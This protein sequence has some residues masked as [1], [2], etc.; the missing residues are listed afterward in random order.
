MRQLVKEYA[1]SITSSLLTSCLNFFGLTV[2][3]AVCMLLM[4][5]VHSETSFERWLP[6]SDK[7]Y[8]V[9]QTWSLPGVRPRESFSTSGALLDAIRADFPSVQVVRAMDRPGTVQLNGEAIE[10]QVRLVDSDFLRIFPFKLSGGSESRALARPDGL[11]ISDRLARRYFGT[12]NALGMQLRITIGDDQR[13]YQVTGVLAPTSERSD[14]R[15]DMFLRLSP[16]RQDPDTFRNW[17]ATMLQTFVRFDTPEDAAAFERQLPAL[18]QRRAIA[19]LGP[20]VGEQLKLRLVPLRSIHLIEEDDRT[21]VG[22]VGLIGLLTLL[23]ACINYVTLSTARAGLRAREIAIRKVVGATRNRLLVQFLAEAVATV[24]IAGVLALALVELSL[25]W[26]NALMATD[27]ELSYSGPDS[28]LSEFAL[29]LVLVGILAGAYPALFLSSFRPA[30][31]LASAREAGGGWRGA[32]AREL[33]V[34]LQF[35]I[36]VAFMIATAVVTLQI[37]FM[38]GTDLGFERSGLLLIPSSRNARL[39]EQQ[40]QSFM[41]RA[42]TIPGFIS[43]TSSDAAPGND[44]V[45]NAAGVRRPGMRGEPPSLNVVVTGPRFFPTYGARVAAGRVFSQDFGMDDFFATQNVPPE[46]ALN[47]VILNRSA[48]ATLNF[49]EPGDALGQRLQI[50]LPAGRRQVTVVGVID[51]LRFNSLRGPVAPTVYLFQSREIPTPVLAIRFSGQTLDGMEAQ[52][53]RLWRSLAPDVPFQTITAEESLAR[54]YTADV[55]RSRVFIAASCVAMLVS[56]LGLY[57]LAYFNAARR[58]K[59]IGIRKALGATRSDILRLMTGQMLRPVL[60][61]NLIAWPLAYLAMQRWLNGF[62]QR[63]DLNPLIFLGA[64]IVALAIAAGTI[65]ARALKIART[66]PAEALRHE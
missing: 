5:F 61:A 56:C 60:L 64:A 53:H 3:I 26:I 45:T 23:V 21:M 58:T 49:A 63:V 30:A 66:A 44:D 34:V 65:S 25:P 40:R 54:Y 37:S 43:A 46:Q 1:R 32:R 51:D 13:I 14:I 18:V 11:V 17:G 36:A 35:A 57:G 7:V 48:L 47:N 33:L 24:V 42:A 4:L 12:A 59:E 9:R 29:G 55:Q 28:I 10:Q 16:E 2:A 52:L 62:D 19:D 20:Q 41:D 22:S 15:A 38:R 8:A 6:Q 39:N 50:D 31:V 27:L